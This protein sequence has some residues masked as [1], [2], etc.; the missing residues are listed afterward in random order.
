M[1][2]AL[3]CERGRKSVVFGTTITKSILGRTLK[4]FG[5]L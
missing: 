1:W 3:A 2:L 4:S 5:I